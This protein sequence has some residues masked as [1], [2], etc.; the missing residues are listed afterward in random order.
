[1]AGP[2]DNWRAAAAEFDA[3]YKAI[4]K[5][6]WEASTPCSEWNVHQ[7]VAHAVGTQA[8]FGGALGGDAPA[9]A[10]WKTARAAM[11]A[12]ISSPGATDGIIN[13][14]PLGG[15][16][17]KAMV[18][19]ICTTDLLIHTW[20]LAR[21]IGANEQLPE[22]LVAGAHHGLQ[23]LPAEAIRVPGRFDAVTEV[24]DDADAQTKMLAFAG[25]KP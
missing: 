4:A 22:D 16:V 10:D 24:P 8:A 1:M 17:P 12:A 7:L 13:F 9:D 20:D 14:P 2:A 6:Q 18:L 25:R 11:E 15:D 23:S 5:D 21:A 3:R 19:G